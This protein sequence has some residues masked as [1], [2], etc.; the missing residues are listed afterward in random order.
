LIVDL[1]ENGVNYFLEKSQPFL[2]NRR[3][4]VLSVC[5]HSF[6]DIEWKQT[7]FRH[8]TK[9]ARRIIENIISSIPTTTS[10]CLTIRHTHLYTKYSFE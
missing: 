6:R 5:A 1:L 2:R 8:D 10:Q 4:I 7:I 9:Y 3:I